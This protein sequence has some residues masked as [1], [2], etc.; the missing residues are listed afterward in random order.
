M[1]L[2]RDSNIKY[3]KYCRKNNDHIYRMRDIIVSR[4]LILSKT[5]H[6]LHIH[7]Y[8]IFISSV[9]RIKNQNIVASG[10]ILVVFRP[11]ME[12]TIDQDML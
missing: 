7:R 3:C 9:N 11:I 10:K 5:S 12:K 8:V 2:F 6:I 1:F 4:G